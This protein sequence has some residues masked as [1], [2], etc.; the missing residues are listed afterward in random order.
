MKEYKYNSW[1]Q[2]LPIPTFFYRPFTR[3]SFET[4]YGSISV[5]FLSYIFRTNAYTLTNSEQQSNSWEDYNRSI[6]QG[7]PCLLWKP[8]FHNG[9]RKTPWLDNILSRFNSICTLMPYFFNICIGI[10]I[11]SAT[12]THLAF[13]TSL[14]T[15]V[16]CEYFT[17]SCVLWVPPISSSFSLSY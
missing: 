7:N 2:F 1:R 5:Y 8:K 12:R 11:P 3:Y 14:P 17:N 6:G 4:I 16:L 9:F 15:T 10:Y 13:L